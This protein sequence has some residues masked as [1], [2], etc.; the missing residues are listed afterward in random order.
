MSQN[1]HI[2]TAGAA[3]GSADK[4][5]I[6]VHGR[7]GS[8]QDILS[9]AKFLRVD[10]YSLLAPQASLHTWYPYSFMAP[11]QS[12][13]PAL[14]SALQAIATTVKK[15]TDAGVALDHIYFFG[16]SQGACLTMEYLAQNASRYG[17]AAAMIGGVIGESVDRSLYKGDFAG[18]PIMLC[19]SD[20][21]PHV[22]ASRVAETADILAELNAEVTKRIYRNFGHSINQEEIELANTLL[23]S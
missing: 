16:F 7:G 20:P 11:R 12:N 15:A 13:E 5:L 3:L 10:G 18:T 23:F 17:G 6:M 1:I 22:P 9:M 19:S 4:A 2:E 21:D 14:T 8:A